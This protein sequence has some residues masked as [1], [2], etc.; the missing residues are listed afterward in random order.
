MERAAARNDDARKFCGT[1]GTRL[2]RLCPACG[3]AN[4]PSDRYCGDCGTG[5][6]DQASTGAELAASLAPPRSRPAPEAERRL[7]TVLFADLVGFTGLAEDRD[8]EAVR[9]L[10]TRYFS[11]ATDIIARYGGTI[12]KFIGDA[13]MAVWG[14]PVAR[15]DDAERAV[16]AALDLIDGVRHLGQDATGSP[17]RARAGVL[18]G[19]AAVSLGSTNQGMVAGDLVNTASR[20]QSVAPPDA[21]LVGDA[22]HAATADAIA[23]EPVGEQSLKGKALPVAAWRAVR[24]LGKVGGVGRSEGLEPPFVGRDDELRLI[25]DMLH[26]AER[27]PTPSIRLDRQANPGPARAGSRGSS[28]STWMGSRAMCT[29]T[30]VALRLTARASPSGRSVRWSVAAPGSP[31]AMTRS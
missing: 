30:R 2:A 23:Y 18:T 20:L 25:K 6:I 5:L 29:G 9:D 21:V 24:V 31:R 15:E 10:L 13:V 26:A 14:A 7:V 27:D 17:L 8:P 3:A 4:G 16:R 19:D 1:C 12:E 11:V 28:T 22:T